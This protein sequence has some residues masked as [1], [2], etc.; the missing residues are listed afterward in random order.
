M[1][2]PVAFASPDRDLV[3]VSACD[4]FSSIR[5]HAQ[6][7]TGCLTADELP[8]LDPVTDE[9]EAKQ[10]LREARAAAYV[11]RTIVPPPPRAPEG[12]QARVRRAAML[13][14]GSLFPRNPG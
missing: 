1:S 7:G 14:A 3:W 12:L 2:N 8:L 11:C 13:V 9:T 5:R 4:G 10:L 6:W